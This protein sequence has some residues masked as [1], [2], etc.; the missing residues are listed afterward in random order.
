[1]STSFNTVTHEPSLLNDSNTCGQCGSP[2]P[3]R[4]ASPSSNRI[5]RR[6]YLS[7]RRILL[8][9]VQSL[10]P[11]SQCFKKDFHTNNDT[12]WH[13]FPPVSMDSPQLLPP[14]LQSLV[15]S[16]NAIG[17]SAHP[18][19]TQSKATCAAQGCK[20]VR[21]N[22]KCSRLMCREHC[23]LQHEGN[24]GVHGAGRLLQQVEAT[25]SD[26]DP[27]VLAQPLDIPTELVVPMATHP[28]PTELITPMAMPTL[29]FTVTAT[30][31]PAPTV[32]LAAGILPS[33]QLSTFPPPGDVT[34]RPRITTQMNPI[35]MAEYL[36]T[37]T[38]AHVASSSRTR[39]DLTSV[40]RFFL[41][42]WNNSEDPASVQFIQ[43]CPNWPTWQLSATQLDSPGTDLTAIQLY[44][45]IHHIWVDVAL[46]HTHHLTTDCAVLIRRKGAR[47]IDEH[48]QIERF[49]PPPTRRFRQGFTAERTVL[50]QKT[51][52][53]GRVG[54]DGQNQDSDIEILD[55]PSSSP[56]KR[57]QDHDMEIAN[58]PK[59]R[60][61]TA[62]PDSSP[63]LPSSPIAIS[64]VHDVFPWTH[65]HNPLE[66][67][68]LCRRW[69]ADWHVVDIVDG[70]K[71][72]DDS[73]PQGKESSESMMARVNRIYGCTIPYSTFNDQRN[74][75]RRAPQ[76]L[77]EEV[78]AAGRTPSGLWSHFA[79][80]VRL[81]ATS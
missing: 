25:S 53:K 36:K 78:L 2:V 17:Q 52:G 7:V 29:P 67:P 41:I 51:K 16:S 74:R 63:S 22:R 42:Y 18:T 24:C 58:G 38:P 46:N 75:W 66:P 59:R 47:G 39:K 20:R 54:V 35:W 5:P 79:R 56:M 15:F 55:E 73:A 21:V 12:W 26:F 4:F 60:R 31:L 76:S 6:F 69:P 80:S 43:D 70:L 14:H 9:I 65:I 23:L 61:V 62:S 68:T 28:P 33:N 44:S 64:P 50:R 71:A 37:P 30:Q 34:R 1:M 10:Y 8:C 48:E 57:R 19:T 27:P 3:I 45:A 32:P 13:I 49:V 77:R 81:K 11:A 40:R 72:V